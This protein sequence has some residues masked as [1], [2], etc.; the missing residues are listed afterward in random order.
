ML[1]VNLDI[2]GLLDL[3]KSLDSVVR[4]EMKN[5]GQALAAA[6]HAHILEEAGKKL[7]STLKPFQ[8]HLTLFPLEGSGENVWVVNLDRK[9]RWIDDGM[10]EHEMIDDLLKS[11]KVK[12][13]KDGSRYLSVPFDHGPGKGKTGSTPAQQS[14][15]A[16]IKK[17]LKNRGIPF[18][19][20]EKGAD[21]K[22]L[23]G[24]LHNIDITKEPLKSIQGPGQGKGPIGQ[25]KQGPTGIPFLQGI[26]I[27]QKMV[28]DPNTGKES[29]KRG[30]MTF[31]TVSSKM[32]GTG[33]WVHP[34][35]TPK[36]LLEEGQKW[37]EDQ[38]SR[39]IAPQLL[40]SVISKV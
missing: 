3:Q 9:Y 15:V 35:L 32:K 8:D 20:I 14:L 13:A 23:M 39:I 25:V 38:W 33:R 37:A 19:K 34:G 17:E 28:K 40:K 4:D 6:T 16:T 31:R 24:T 36:N 1:L 10:E 29:V 11:K 21:G 22:P 30:I 2:S 12:T 26:R 5:A 7:H 27:T 18:G